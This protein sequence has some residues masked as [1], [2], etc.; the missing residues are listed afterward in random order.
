M[1]KRGL[2]LQQALNRH[3][4]ER[5]ALGN[6]G[7]GLAALCADLVNQ[8]GPRM[9]GKIAEGCCLGRGTIERIGKE[10]GSEYY[11]PKTSTIERILK[12]YRQQGIFFEVN[13]DAEFDNQPK[14]EYPK[15][16]IGKGTKKV[17]KLKADLKIA[18]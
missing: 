12:Y 7:E 8:D 5:R 6:T 17:A 1:S 2:S 3:S 9:F 14:K 10:G 11:D 16:A 18:A 15:S 4:L 13:Q